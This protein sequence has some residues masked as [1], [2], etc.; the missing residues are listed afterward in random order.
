MTDKSIITAPVIS[1]S[2]LRMETDGEGITTLVCF[3]GC[4]LRCKYCLNPFSFDSK[5][6]RKNETPL[7]LY[8]SVKKDE[9][10]FLATGGGVTFGGGE[11]LLYPDFLE[12]FRLCCGEKYHLC[13]ETSLN[14]PA[15]NVYIAAECIDTFYVDC[16]DTNPSIYKSYTGKDNK[17]MLENLKILLSLV[18][19]ERIVVRVPLIREFNTEQD[20]EKSVALLSEM[21]ITQFDLFEYKTS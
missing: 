4:P 14:V 13:A 1:F 19:G 9:L 5:T 10:Y 7:S 17:N 18:G 2:R 15:E 20:R 12:E 6:K 21:G 8:E 11:P 3:H 16:K